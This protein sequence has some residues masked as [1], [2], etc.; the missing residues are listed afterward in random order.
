MTM[1]NNLNF[2]VKI[3]RVYNLRHLSNIRD[4]HSGG[5]QD[6]CN[7]RNIGYSGHSDGLQNLCFGGY[8]HHHHHQGSNVNE[9]NSAAVGDGAHDGLT[10]LT[11]S[12]EL[13]E[14]VN[15]QNPAKFTVVVNPIHFIV[16]YEGGYYTN[17]L[18]MNELRYIVYKLNVG[19]YTFTFYMC[20]TDKVYRAVFE[21]EVNVGVFTK[22]IALE[23]SGKVACAVYN[24]SELDRTRPVKV[25][26]KK[27]I[28][29]NK[30]R[31]KI[32]GK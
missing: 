2:Y 13:T 6:L 20:Y 18:F 21:S 22:M 3:F 11:D 10:K 16:R 15:L 27:K 31:V 8:N 23:L 29:I 14:L 26:I 4:D 28:K 25:D 9:V 7:I 17:V 1:M 12:T 5:L 32:C 30:G 24:I 19:V